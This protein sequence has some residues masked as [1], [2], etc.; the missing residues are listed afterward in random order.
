MLL[1]LVSFLF[2]SFYVLL[3]T[4]SSITRIRGPRLLIMANDRL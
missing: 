1:T 4:V 3:C 2:E